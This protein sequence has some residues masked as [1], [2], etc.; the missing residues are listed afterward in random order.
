MNRLERLVVHVE[1]AI[2][3]GT[4]HD[5]PHLRLGLMMI[6]SAAELMMYRETDYL[7]RRGAQYE[8]MLKQAEKALAHGFGNQQSVDRL[9]ADVFSKTQRRKIEREFNAKCDLLTREGIINATHARVLKKLHEYRNETYHRD[10]LR[11]ATL[12]SATRIFIHLVCTMMTVMPVHGM[13]Y[14]SDPPDGL[15]KYLQSKTLPSN[16]PMDMQARIGHQLLAEL[17]IGEQGQIGQDL[18]D[19][20]I[21]RLGEIEEA[22]K[23]C[24]SYFNDINNR[25][26]DFQ[27]I[28][29]LL[30]APEPDDPHDHLRRT[31]ENYRQWARPVNIATFRAW[32]KGANTL[33]RETDDLAAFA[34]F[35]DLEDEF[36]PIEQLVIKL[37]LDVDRSVQHEIDVALGK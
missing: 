33:A 28:L 27:S 2:R 36:E 10:E 14:S 17:G 24:V 35:A 29:G 31:V 11:P 4:A 37:A 7:L 9:R 3:F 13:G 21:Y 30:Q 12:A 1:E 5:E 22:A 15:K 26:W 16:D 6:D 23:E 20:V 8:Q 18:A 25:G 19:H 32:Q 34:A